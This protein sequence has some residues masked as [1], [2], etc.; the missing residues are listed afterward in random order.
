MV[1]STAILA[2][3]AGATP[4][5]AQDLSK[6][7]A[8]VLT[9]EQRADA[10]GMIERDIQNRIKEFNARHRETWYKVKTR[11]QWGQYRDERIARL[12]QSLGEWPTPARPNVK[13]TGVVKGDGFNIEN[14]VY[15]SRPGF[16]VTGNL[17]VPAKP[18]KSMPGLLI[19]HAH[20][21]RKRHP[22]LQD[23]GMT[24]AR[25]GCLVLVIDQVGYGERRSHPFNKDDDYVKP[26][27]AGRQDYYFRYDT[28]IQLQ[29]LGDSLMGWMAWDL[30]RGV[31]LLLARDGVDAKRIAILGGVAGGGDPAGGLGLPANA[32]RR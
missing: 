22:E 7:A 29:L 12:R 26:Y 1:A 16:W 20:H 4:L 10:R 32:R 25:S 31:D 18:G 5:I 2:L 21:N 30:M 13:V 14:V 27:K 15:E 11:E 9:K 23:M 17:Y 8:D 3:A 19:A 24:W 6:V 28:G